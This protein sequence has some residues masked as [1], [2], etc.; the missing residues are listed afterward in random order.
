[1]TVNSNCGYAVSASEAHM[2]RHLQL[3][4]R[5]RRR[6]RTSDFKIGYN[7]RGA[8]TGW[9]SQSSTH[10]T[11]QIILATSA[12]PQDPG[13]PTSNMTR[14]VLVA[15]LA[16][17]MLCSYLASASPD[18]A[19]PEQGRKLLGG[20]P[21]SY[22]CERSAELAMLQRGIAVTEV[23]LPSL[24]AEVSKFT[25]C[26]WFLTSIAAPALSYAQ[27]QATYEGVLVPH[28]RKTSSVPPTRSWV[29]LHFQVTNLQSATFPSARTTTHAHNSS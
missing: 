2:K 21:F 4:C 13:S 23:S 17:L 11:K 19:Q 18:R 24:A 7:I 26:C 25:R 22:A 10:L 20:S 9:H 15:A 5:R 28:I 6:S 14:R 29:V 8:C 12:A 27:L 3:T 1:M 16:A